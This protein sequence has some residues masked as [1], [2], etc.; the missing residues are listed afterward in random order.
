MNILLDDLFFRYDS[1]LYKLCLGFPV[2]AERV[3]EA[4]MG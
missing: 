2:I 4:A 3:S 1:R